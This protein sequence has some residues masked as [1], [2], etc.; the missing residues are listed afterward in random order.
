MGD[1]WLRDATSKKD[2]EMAVDRKLDMSQ[3]GDAAA[4]KSNVILG[5]M[6]RSMFTKSCEVLVRL[7]SALVRPH[8]ECCVQFWTPHF[9]KDA[10]KLEQVQRRVTRMI[11]GLSYRGGARS[12]LNHPR[13]QDTQLID[14]KLY[15]SGKIALCK[16]L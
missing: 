3:Q 14:K 11:R 15:K 6:N 12:V 4:K 7:Y 2:L 16:W 8:L 10:N 9:K 13:V 1:T 5:C